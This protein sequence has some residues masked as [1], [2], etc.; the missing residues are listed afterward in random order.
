M[1]EA[2]GRMAEAHG[3]EFRTVRAIDLVEKMQLRTDLRRARDQR[4]VAAVAAAAGWLLALVA[5]VAA[6]L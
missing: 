3:E 5:L 4:D 6:A 2:L 1:T